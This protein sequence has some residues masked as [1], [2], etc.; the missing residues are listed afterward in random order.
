MANQ[1]AARLAGDDYQHLLAW[2]QILEM[3]MPGS[4]VRAV[5]VEDP[6]AAH[7][8]DIT[9]LYEKEADHPDEFLQVK[10]H[11]DHREQYTTDCSRPRRVA[12]SFASLRISLAGSD[13]RKTAQVVR[14]SR[15]K[16]KGALKG[17]PFISCF[18]LVPDAQRDFGAG[19]AVD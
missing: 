2:L 3:Q 4:Q 19:P 16:Q 10:Y 7:V 9:T 17:A 11:V 12:S 6:D 15:P 5:I 1:V 18:I 14:S 8:D 13:A